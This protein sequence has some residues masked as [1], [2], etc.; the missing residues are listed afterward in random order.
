MTGT[1]FFPMYPL[2]VARPCATSAGEKS[3]SP[4]TPAM[5]MLAA[6]ATPCIDMVWGTR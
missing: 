5:K 6:S 2:R 1:M 3:L 4:S